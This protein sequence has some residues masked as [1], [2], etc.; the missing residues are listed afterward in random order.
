MGGYF[1]V[2][3]RMTGHVFIYELPL[4]EQ[5]WP[6]ASAKLISVWKPLKR[7]NDISALSFSDGYIFANFDDG[8]SNHVLIF[9]VLE[10]GLPGEL[11]EQ[12]QVDVTNAE[13]MAL[14]KVDEDSWEVFFTSDSQRAIFA[15]T[16]QF[17]TGFD[18]HPKC[19]D[20]GGAM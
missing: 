13:G 20:R 1:Y 16:F 14:R 15:Y 7:N 11:K 5:T 9:P 3:S 4:L 17:V 12:Y 6:L 8:S 18:L 10:N 2:G 19:A